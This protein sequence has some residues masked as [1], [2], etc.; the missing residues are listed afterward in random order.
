MKRL[1]VVFVFSFGMVALFGIACG[2]DGDGTA[3]MDPGLLGYWIECDDRG[4][5]SGDADGY[6]W[7]VVFYGNGDIIRVRWDGATV[8]EDANGPFDRVKYAIDGQYA[9]REGGLGTYALTAVTLNTGKT[10]PLLSTIENGQTTYYLMVVKLDGSSSEMD[11]LWD[12]SQED[13]QAYLADAQANGDSLGPIRDGCYPT[14]LDGTVTF[15]S[16]FADPEIPSIQVTF[17]GGEMT[18]LNGVAC[19][20]VFP[21]QAPTFSDC[22]VELMCGCCRVYFETQD[23]NS[24][25]NIDFPLSGSMDACEAFAFS[26]DFTHS[27]E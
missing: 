7:G 22:R 17:S 16:D 5:I 3:E 8:V 9:T 19:E 10:F 1:G 12:C 18:A 4:F 2:D 13:H 21:D 14:T 6:A 25:Y 11:P 27:M 24:A 26:G 23:Y 15:E 20:A